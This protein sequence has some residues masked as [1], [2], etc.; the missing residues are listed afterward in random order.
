[1]H[2]HEAPWDACWHAAAINNGHQRHNIQEQSSDFMTDPSG[3]PPLLLLLL[4][5]L[6]R[7]LGSYL[8]L[9]IQS[10]VLLL[11]I[12]DFLGVMIQLL[13]EPTKG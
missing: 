1:L 3:S 4:L 8:Q 9:M 11:Q 10:E 12:L 6:H 13:F 7:W 5:L 2:S